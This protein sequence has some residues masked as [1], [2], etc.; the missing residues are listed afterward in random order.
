[1]HRCENMPAGIREERGLEGAREPSKINTVLQQS[2]LENPC[3]LL[4]DLSPLASYLRIRLRIYTNQ[5]HPSYLASPGNFTIHPK[6][7]AGSRNRKINSE[8]RVFC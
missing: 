6:E 5:H 7:H 3:I 2:R 8:W 1:M 4:T